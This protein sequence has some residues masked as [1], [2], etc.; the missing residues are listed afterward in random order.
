VT[1]PCENQDVSGTTVAPRTMLRHI[2]NAL[3][4][5]RIAA[6]PVFAWLVIGGEEGRSLPAAIVFTFAAVTDYVDGALSRRWRVITRF[7]RILDPIADR[8]LIDTAVVL[9]WWYDRV[10]LVLLVLVL[11]RDLLLLLGL[12]VA[13]GRGYRLRVHPVGKAGTLVTMVGLLLAMV[14]AV[15]SPL[16]AVVIW[17]GVVLLLVAG[18]LYARDLR[19]HR[20]VAG[21]SA[22]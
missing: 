8:L 22:P 11:G 21:G 2:P 14:L 17:S 15:G 10:P 5:I 6:V 3:T 20:R 7:G 19:E 9:L 13:S 16:T 4:T 18:V 1:S 12:A